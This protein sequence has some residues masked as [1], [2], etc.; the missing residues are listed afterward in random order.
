LLINKNIGALCCFFII[1]M[2]LLGISVSSSTSQ[3][4]ITEDLVNINL[5]ENGSH[6]VAMITE[7]SINDIESDSNL[8]KETK[9]AQSSMNQGQAG[10]EAL[11]DIL[12]STQPNS[13]DH[14][15]SMSLEEDKH[16]AAFTGLQTENHLDT[17]KERYKFRMNLERYGTKNRKLNKVFIDKQVLICGSLPGQISIQDCFEAFILFSLVDTNPA[18]FVLFSDKP[19]KLL[20]MFN[21]YREFIEYQQFLVSIEDEVRDTL[22]DKLLGFVIQEDAVNFE[23]LS[24]N[25]KAYFSMTKDDMDR[26][27]TGFLPKHLTW[28]GIRD[29]ADLDK[30]YPAFLNYDLSPEYDGESIY[31]YLVLL[32]VLACLFGIVASVLFNQ[33]YSNIR[34]FGLENSHYYLL[35]LLLMNSLLL[36][37]MYVNLVS[38]DKEYPLR[39]PLVANRF[40]L[41]YIGY[42]FDITLWVYSLW[43][44]KGFYREPEHNYSMGKSVT[45]GL[46]PFLVQLVTRI[47]LDHHVIIIDDIFRVLDYRCV[48][49]L[50]SNWIL[51]GIIYTNSVYIINFSRYIILVKLSNFMFTFLISFGSNAVLFLFFLSGET[52][53][54]NMGFYVADNFVKVSL[55]LLRAFYMNKKRFYAYLILDELQNEGT[56]NWSNKPAIKASVSRVKYLTVTSD[57]AN[58]ND[59][60]R[61]SLLLSVF[62]ISKEA[63]FLSISSLA[64]KETKENRSISLIDGNSIN[65]DS[66]INSSTMEMASRRN[67]TSLSVST[68]ISGLSNANN[69]TADQTSNPE[70]GS[71]SEALPPIVIINPSL[72]DFRGSNTRTSLITSKRISQGNQQNLLQ[73][74]HREAIEGD[75]SG[76]SSTSRTKNKK[77]PIHRV[78][79]TSVYDSDWLDEKGIEEILDSVDE[80]S[81]VYGDGLDC[82]SDEL[83][84]I[85]RACVDRLVLANLI[86]VEEDILCSANSLNSD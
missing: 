61:F 49:I 78:R 3:S 52:T 58:S 8:R 60:S 16:Y 42:V 5:K 67:S 38:K 33:F 28:H 1:K 54:F 63:A 37:S 24:D 85:D 55:T 69:D 19:D 64:E 71:E 59:H 32:M 81:P 70:R 29:L 76:N 79:N 20:L 53:Y 10:K 68:T 80:R 6:E 21:S 39:T 2:T 75:D 66:T 73:S 18:V 30:L 23:S 9:E 57:L 12:G 27:K 47:L 4:V 41:I 11:T 86:Q 51:C 84:E 14:T 83:K 36:A 50:A 48:V 26:M 74:T 45:I 43:I 34:D 56:Q 17:V 62:S 65:N 35:F 82:G 44:S 31:I 13:R 46:I 22:E 77:S 15:N 72:Y 40:V 7:R 25:E